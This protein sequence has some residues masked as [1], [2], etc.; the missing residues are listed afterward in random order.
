MG[1]VCR[2]NRLF[3]T[4]L[5][6]HFRPVAASEPAVK[7]EYLGRESSEVTIGGEQMFNKAYA[8]GCEK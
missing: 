4:S 5:S 7:F 1:S 3:Y 6:L 2:I 8:I